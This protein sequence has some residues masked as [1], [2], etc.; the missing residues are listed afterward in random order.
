[1]GNYIQQTTTL[2]TETTEQTTEMTTGPTTMAATEKTTNGLVLSTIEDTTTT[3]SGITT[4]DEP[5][6]TSIIPNIVSSTNDSCFCPCNSGGFQT[7]TFE[8]LQRKIQE[9]VAELKIDPK[10]T[11]IA[12][13]K[14]ISVPDGRPSAKAVGS[15]GIVILLTFAALIILM[16]VNVVYRNIMQYWNRRQN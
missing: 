12:K 1:M 11:S 9:I 5:I 16:D 2:L 10:E 3:K 14:L 8:E 4:S 6:T 7:L 13:R 15:L